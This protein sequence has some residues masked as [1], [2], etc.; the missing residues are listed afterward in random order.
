MLI[1]NYVVS[2]AVG[3]ALFLVTFAG[4]IAREPVAV[5]ISPSP[6]VDRRAT[7][8]P[9]VPISAQLLTS[10]DRAAAPQHLCVL[11]DS[12]RLAGLV[13]EQQSCLERWEPG[14]HAT[15]GLV[16]SPDEEA[17]HLNLINE[18]NLFRDGLGLPPV[19]VIDLR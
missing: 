5:T 10:V 6:R 4:Q 8:Y 19:M 7:G 13:H 1:P 18:T 3:T 16:S 12:P 2:S 9:T 11:I 17:K 14:L 15:V